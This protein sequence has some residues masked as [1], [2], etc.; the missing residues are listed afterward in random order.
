M[1]AFGLPDP[2]MARSSL[3]LADF[4]GTWRVE[5]QITDQIGPHGRFSG[6]ARFAPQAAGLSYHEAGMLHLG[7]G[8]ALAAERRYLW[9][10]DGKS[11]V[12]DF[13]DGRPFHRFD[14]RHSP[15]TAR[16]DCAPDLYLVR[17]DLGSWPKWQVEWRVTG[18]RKDYRM[19]TVY[20]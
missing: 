2:G 18:P 4:V 20:L 15:A 14:P 5:R 7:D 13:E 17:Y 9:R 6:T 12:V 16:H 1:A 10:A 11:I 8:P 19:V 3:H